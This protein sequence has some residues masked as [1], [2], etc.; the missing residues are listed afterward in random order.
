MDAA[1]GSITFIL[2]LRPDARGRLRG[3]VQRVLTREASRFEG[4]E[5]LVEILREAVTGEGPIAPGLGAGAEPRPT[6]G[7]S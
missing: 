5:R 1:R 2:R 6:E 4:D 7:Q 3:E